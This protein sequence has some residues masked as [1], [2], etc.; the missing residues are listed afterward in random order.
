MHS[1]GRAVAVI[2]FALFVCVPLSAW[3]EEQSRTFPTTLKPSQEIITTHCRNGFFRAAVILKNAGGL[4]G[5]YVLVPAIRDS[6]IPYFDANG[7]HL[8]SFHIFDSAEKKKTAST[9]IEQLRREFP[10]E[11]TVD[12][13]NQRGQTGASRA[14]RRAP[15]FHTFLIN[16]PAGRESRERTNPST[17]SRGA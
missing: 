8:T 15:A 6:S 1:S 5:G 13:G 16:C 3:A 14:A 7:V 9:V 10:L 2:Q 4:T 12:C 17:T 11:E